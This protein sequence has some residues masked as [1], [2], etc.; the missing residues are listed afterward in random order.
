MPRTQASPHPRIIGEKCRKHQREASLVALH[1]KQRRRQ[2]LA[3][4]RSTLTDLVFHGARL[5]TLK[6]FFRAWHEVWNKERLTRGAFQVKSGVILQEMRV[7]KRAS[8][9]EG[10]SATKDDGTTRINSGIR[11]TLMQRPRESYRSVHALLGLYMA[12]ANHC[13]ACSYHPGSYS[14]SCPKT[15]LLQQRPPC[16]AGIHR[17]CMAHYR[18]RWSCCDDT[19]ECA[20][21]KEVASVGGTF[22]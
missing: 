2:L 9:R 3:L 15:P 17:S 20:F 8:G 12:S 7:R 11:Q 6:T 16:I 13:R 4:K 5:E 10:A 18:R 19:D 1:G 14:V 22:P 21:G